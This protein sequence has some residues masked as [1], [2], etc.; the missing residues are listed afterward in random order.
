MHCYDHTMN[1]I[2]DE[3]VHAPLMIP[4]QK[5]IS[6]TR[7]SP[8]ANTVVRPRSRPSN[9]P[10]RHKLIDLEENVGLFPCIILYVI[11]LHSDT[12]LL[13]SHHRQMLHLGSQQFSH[14]RN[15]PCVHSFQPSI[16]C[17]L[18]G[19]EKK[20]VVQFHCQGIAVEPRLRGF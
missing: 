9:C 8:R 18:I 14:K 2:K 15:Y 5:Q 10:T 12:Q 7:Q 1:R 13:P 19:P 3:I 6:L 11:T 20:P 4:T 17:S 16:N